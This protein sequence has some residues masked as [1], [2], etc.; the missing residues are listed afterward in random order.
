MFVKSNGFCANFF[1][2]GVFD[3]FYFNGGNDFCG[4]RL[5]FE[6]VYKMDGFECGGFDCGCLCVGFV[7]GV[8]YYVGGVVG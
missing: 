7:Y 3:I 4:E 2:H 1:V 6:F 8:I 5:V